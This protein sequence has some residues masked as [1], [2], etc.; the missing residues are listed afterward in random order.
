VPVR[1]VHGD[2]AHCIREKSE[3]SSIPPAADA[4]ISGLAGL[5]LMI[6]VAD[7]QAV[8]LYDPVEKVSAN[9]HSGWRGSIRNIVGKTVRTMA[10]EFGCRPENVLAGIGPSLGPCCAE[11]VHYRS[12]IP[13]TLWHYRV[14]EHHFDFWSMTR[15]QLAAERVRVENILCANICT[16]CHTGDFY[17]YRAEKITGRFAAVIGKRPARE[18]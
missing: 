6:Q 4:L 8:L 17:S 14:S 3:I 13:E 15:D 10:A 7:C 12:E 16:V 5:G 11:F 2:D 9:I 18:Q 1:Q